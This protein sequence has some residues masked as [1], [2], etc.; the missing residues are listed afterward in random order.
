[1]RYVYSIFAL[2][3]LSACSV[4]ESKLAE[5]S[6]KLGASDARKF[7]ESVPSMTTMQME[8]A[9]IEIR[10]NEY[11]YREAGHDKAANAYV[12]AFEAYL[13]ENSDSLAKII[14]NEM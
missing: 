4:G 8:G 2:W 1:M 13:R 12:D 14:F 5:E 3:L 11:A 10:A 9:L 6:S 7:I